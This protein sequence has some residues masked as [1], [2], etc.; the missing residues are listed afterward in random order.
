MSK[1]MMFRLK[2]KATDYLWVVN[3]VYNC[4]YHSLEISKS[5]IDIVR[6]NCLKILAL[7]YRT[8]VMMA[9]WVFKLYHLKLCLKLS[10]TSRPIFSKERSSV[11]G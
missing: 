6:L 3:T 8:Q 11:Q 10:L 2:S 9:F 7:N 1:Q 5:F 4:Y